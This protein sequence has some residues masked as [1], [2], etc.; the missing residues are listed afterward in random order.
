MFRFTFVSFYAS[1]TLWD[2]NSHGALQNEVGSISLKVLILEKIGQKKRTTVSH[3]I[4]VNTHTK[5]WGHSSKKDPKNRKQI[6]LKTS[7]LARI[8]A[9]KKGEISKTGVFIFRPPKIGPLGACYSAHFE[10]ALKK[11]S[12]ENFGF[13]ASKYALYAYQRPNSIFQLTW[14]FEKLGGRSLRQH[15]LLH[16]H[17]NSG[18]TQKSASKSELPYFFPKNPGFDIFSTDYC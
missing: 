9:E 1:L 16:W 6:E 5:S 11:K 12:I 7:F 14:H 18:S 17:E 3:F 2:T 13:W 8:G 15:C 10:R 4:G